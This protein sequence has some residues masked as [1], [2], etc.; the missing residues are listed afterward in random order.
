MNHRIVVICGNHPRNIFFL[1]KIAEEYELCGVIIEIREAFIPI[2]DPEYSTRDLK[3]FTKHFSNRSMFEQQ[4][5]GDYADLPDC[6]IFEVNSENLSSKK[7]ADFLRLSRPDSVYV[8]GASMIRGELFNALPEY[9][10]N[11]HSGIVPRYK[12]YASTFWAFYFLEPNWAGGSFH[13][14]GKGADS[15]P[16]I[17]QIVPE[18]SRG[19]TMHEVACKMTLKAGDEVLK[20]IDSLSGGGSLVKHT[21]KTG[22]L[23][24][25]NDFKVEHLRVVYEFYGDGIVDDYLDGRI[26]PTPVKLITL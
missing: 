21:Q 15:G 2:P 6:P 8:Y 19:D 25:A 10:I 13:I 7:T 22:R 18:L 1:S 17:H 12:G 24:L 23:F 26:N 20:I 9:T 14:V 16:I 4:Y 3:N 5:F 11:L